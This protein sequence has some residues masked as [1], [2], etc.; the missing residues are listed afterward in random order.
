MIQVI[1]TVSLVETSADRE[2][3]SNKAPAMLFWVN[4][5]KDEVQNCR[6]I[7]AINTVILRDDQI[8]EAPEISWE[9]AAKGVTLTAKRNLEQEHLPVH[10]RMWSIVPCSRDRPDKAQSCLSPKAGR[11]DKACRHTWQ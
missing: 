4:T 2:I 7:A 9:P 5:C 1:L 8:N 11:F 10:E 6:Q 3:L